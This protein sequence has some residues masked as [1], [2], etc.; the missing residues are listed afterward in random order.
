MKFD[1]LR[2]VWARQ[3]QTE[4]V[5]VGER[6]PKCRV[7]CN[8]IVDKQNEQS[9][10]QTCWTNSQKTLPQIA[11]SPLGNA[12]AKCSCVCVCVRVCEYVCMWHGYLLPAGRVSQMPLTPS[13]SCYGIAK[14]WDSWILNPEC[15]Q[16]REKRNHRASF[17]EFRWMYHLLCRH[18]SHTCLYTNKQFPEL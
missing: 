1:G 6:L 10:R 7:N 16:T 5:R 15:L 18:S 12:Y 2:Q 8:S 4:W 9:R 13:V 17:K 11:E 14:P 3:R